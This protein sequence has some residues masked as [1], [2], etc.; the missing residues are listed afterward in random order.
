MLKAFARFFFFLSIFG[1][2]T[3]M[4]IYWSGSAWTGEMKRELIFGRSE[5]GGSNG[6]NSVGFID[7]VTYGL[8]FLSLGSWGERK[9]I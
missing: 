1:A 4:L 9:A 5:N 8:F 2:S 6:E 7:R 3:M